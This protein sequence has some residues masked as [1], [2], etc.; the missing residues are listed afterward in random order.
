MMENFAVGELRICIGQQFINLRDKSVCFPEVK[1]PEIGKKG[2]VDEILMLRGL[3]RLYAINVKIECIC[4][5][6]RRVFVRN[7]V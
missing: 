1:W 4:L 2:F 6:L 3:E 7:P 5:I